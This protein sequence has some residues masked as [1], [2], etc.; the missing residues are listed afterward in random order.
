MAEKKKR[1]SI[2]GFDAEHYRRTE[3]YVR[4]IENLYNRAIAD[5]ADLSVKGKIDTEKP[6]S[7]KDYP[8]TRDYAQKVITKLASSMISVIESGSREEWLYACKKN[9]EFLNSILNTSKIEKDLLERM[10][11]RNLDALKTFQARKVNGLDL[12][13]RVWRYVDQFKDQMELGIDVGIGE[14]RSAQQLARDLKQNLKDP[15][16]L[17]RRVR[18]KR[19]NLHLSKNAKA[20]NPG[21]GVYRSSVKNAQRLTR[22][23]IN[24]AYRES[25][26]LRWQKLD[27]VVGFEIKVSNRHHE[28]LEKVWNKQNPGKI[29]ICD[30]LTGKYPKWFKF[31]GWHPQCY[32]DDSYVLT[33]RGWKLFK[34][35]RDDDLIFSLNP[36]SRM[37]EW[38]NIVQ[39]QKYRKNGKM[40]RFHNKTLD[41]LVTPEH[42]MVYLNKNN[43][44]IRKKPASEYSK[45]N[46]GFYRG[47]EW[48]GNPQSFV[49]IGEHLFDM[50]LFAEFMGYWLSDG[51]LVRDGQI[52][53]AQRDGDK[54]RER[55]VRCIRNL[56]LEPHKIK[57]GIN[58]YS[59]DLNNYLKQFGT[60][61]SKFIPDCIKN[62]DKRVIQSFL[63][64]FISCDG[65]TRESKPFVGNRGT[66]CTPK[67]KERVY[68]TSSDKMAADIGE[69]IIKVGGRPSYAVDRIAGQDHKFSNGVYTIN[70]DHYRIR[71]CKSVTAT[72][73]SK[74]YVEY[75][76]YVYDLTLEK[77]HIMYIQ[78]NGKCFWGS[79]CMCYA[80]PIIE[81]FFSKDR[82]DDRVNRL[83]A[84]LNGDEY[85]K[86]TSKQTVNDVPDGFKE[87]IQ[88]NAEKQLN[89]KSVPYFVEDNFKG[90][91]IVKGLKHPPVS[92]VTPKITT[93]SYSSN[94]PSVLRPKSPYLR[95]EDY[96]F[97]KR[98]FDLMDKNKPVKLVVSKKGGSFFNLATK[99]VNIADTNRNNSEWHRKAVVYHEFGHVIDWQRGLRISEEIKAL[100]DRHIKMLRKRV[101][102]VKRERTY[103]IVNGKYELVYVK[104]QVTSSR[105]A[106]I[107]GKLNEIAYR[108]WRM[109]D[110]TFSK[111][112][113]TKMDV[114]EQI[115][116]T[117]DT[118]KSLVV[119]YGDGHSDSYF[120]KAGAKE[121]EYIAHAFENAFIG[122]EVFK[123][124]LPDIYQEMI[125]YIR[126]L[127]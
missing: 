50:V 88:N 103:Q 32:S 16:R 120:K 69:L 94:M 102:Y 5:L 127:K 14:G 56:G 60:A 126:K 117:R 49:L 6:F 110:E 51:S 21:Q 57:A 4:V 18:D 113:I 75:D 90:G 64:A 98:F 15:D 11:D 3:E 66:I 52:F 23:E 125:D 114:I 105:V 100:R 35:V 40:I 2:Q 119:S 101:T 26:W 41:C 45:N 8:K 124:Y 71:E 93:P 1:F 76:G 36:V 86:Y 53:I 123:K 46:G 116:A 58:I 42:E 111:R 62:A 109:K 39:K 30:Q 84:A 112:G 63:D 22:S 81:D 78:R 24:M 19:G 122:N 68:F 104:Q 9:D 99:T 95:G 115:T 82:S 61:S 85:K 83:R 47:C 31:R 92:T 118:I 28:W 20:F 107:D 10:Q 27:F 80:I 25:D 91:I 70:Y 44:D 73:F 7:F 54:N 77:N 74:D 33:K 12:S 17:F 87:W 43:G 97:D 38:V 34:D 13:K 65:H 59:R 37:P 96:T 121:A 55:I 79:N 106:Y 72:V 89:W 67:R 108:I 48:S 29:E